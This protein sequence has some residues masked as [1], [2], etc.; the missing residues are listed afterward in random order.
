MKRMRKT[1]K[2]RLTVLLVLAIIVVAVL[3]LLGI[4]PQWAKDLRAKM[5]PT[6]VTEKID[7]TVNK[8]K[9]SDGLRKLQDLY[10]EYVS[11]E[12]ASQETKKTAATVSDQVSGL[13]IPKY[14]QGHQVVAHEGYTLSY[15][16][17]YEQP[18]WVAYVL[19]V[20]ELNANN[21]S[22]TEDFREDPAIATESAHL[23]DYRNSGYDRGHLCPSADRTATVSENSETFYLSN[24]SPQIHRFNAGLWLKAEGAVRDA[25]RQYGTLYVVAGPVF[26]DNMKT[27]GSCEVA[28]PESFY[29][30]LL[31]IDG[32][33]NATA[34][35]LVCPQEYE[36]GNLK[37]YLCTVN[38][39]EKLTGLDFFPSLDDS[40]EERI[41]SVYTISDWP[42]VFGK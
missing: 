14:V 34:I 22:R 4:G 37:P 15:N 41:E 19:T 11:G 32:D 38:D 28:V 5:I 25:A 31:A 7:M 8:V 9:D 24:M 29:K 33:G 10:E 21:T 23:D 39:V 17:Q 18:D 42:T 16:E 1:T 30:V 40:V 12:N 36:N 6:T 20:E 27:I 2:K 26:T 3:V 13:E 35:G